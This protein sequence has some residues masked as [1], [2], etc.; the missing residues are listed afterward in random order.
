MPPVLFA[1]GRLVSADRGV[2]VAGSRDADKGATDFASDLSARLVAEGLSVLSGLAEGIDTAAHTAALG[3]AGR[4]VAFL[5]TRINRYYPKQNRE[6]QDRI[7]AEGLLLSQFWPDAPGR[8]H[9]FPM[10]NAVMSGYGRA[11]VIVAAGERSGTRIQ[12]RVAIEHGR[13]V[14]LT[15]RVVDTTSWAKKLLDRPGVHQAASPAAVIDVVREI[16]KPLADQIRDL[17]ST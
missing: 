1:R 15:D 13:P 12:A 11:T 8:P 7:V 14:I 2:C 17:Q 16:T 4:T 6:L 3:S 5:G 9:T 10:R